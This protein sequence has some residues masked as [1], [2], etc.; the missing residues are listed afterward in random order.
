MMYFINSRL[1]PGAT[2]E[3]VKEHLAKNM[4]K[5]AWELVKKGIVTHWSYKVGEE[6]GVIALVSHDSL[7]E[8]RALADSAPS[9]KE[10][11]LEFEIDP[12]DHFPR[13]D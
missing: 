11:L 7:E 4:D 2:R 9:V 1:A 13:F 10:G 6:P 5:S 12:V 3:Q 8:V